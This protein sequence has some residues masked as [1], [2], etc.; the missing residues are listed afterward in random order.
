MNKLVV[1][2]GAFNRKLL[3]DRLSDGWT[4]VHYEPNPLLHASYNHEDNPHFTLVKKAVCAKA[5]IVPLQVVKKHREND[6]LDLSAT[7]TYITEKIARDA[8]YKHIQ[9]FDVEAVTLTDVLAP[10]EE[11]DELNVNC[12]GEEVRL[13]LETPMETLLKC[14]MMLV[15]YHGFVEFIG[16]TKDQV[17]QCNDR[18]WPHFDHGMPKKW[19][20]NWRYIRR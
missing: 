7:T 13:M 11:V 15:E 19:S 12:E 18:L 16:I 4:V 17:Q 6:I 9:F 5:G 3:D 1:S 2:I 14:K 20:W 8:E 10:F